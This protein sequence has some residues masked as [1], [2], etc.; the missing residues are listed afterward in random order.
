MQRLVLP[1]GGMPTTQLPRRISLKSFGES[2]ASVSSMLCCNMLEVM[3]STH[4]HEAALPQLTPVHHDHLAKHPPLVDVQ[5]RIQR[6]SLE[7]GSDEPPE[8]DGV[9]AART[10]SQE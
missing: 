9:C 7:A 8:G 2:R 4:T 10:S 6:P 1:L 5:C 3:H